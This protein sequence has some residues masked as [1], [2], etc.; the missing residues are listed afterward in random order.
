MKKIITTILIAAAA[1]TACVQNN[2]EI[3]VKNE[4]ISFSANLNAPESRTVLVEQ[5]GKFHAEWTAGDHI[6]LFEVTNNGGTTKKGNNPVVT[7]AEGAQ[8]RQITACHW[9]RCS[10]SKVPHYKK[11]LQ[12]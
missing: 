11:I 2:D 6:E 1:L 7:L 12:Q 3:I 4:K 5:D 10:A 8:L 9:L